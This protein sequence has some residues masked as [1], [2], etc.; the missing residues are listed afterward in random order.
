[1]NAITVAKDIA[2]GWKVQAQVAIDGRTSVDPILTS[3]QTSKIHVRSLNLAKAADKKLD[4]LIKMLNDALPAM[5]VCWASENW[6]AFT[7]QELSFSQVNTMLHNGTCQDNIVPNINPNYFKTAFRALC[8]RTTAEVPRLEEQALYGMQLTNQKT[9]K[10]SEGDQ[11]LSSRVSHAF[12]STTMQRSGPS[13]N[14]F[15][16]HI[17]NLGF[18]TRRSGTLMDLKTLDSH[19]VFEMRRPC[20][21]A[22]VATLCLGMTSTARS[23]QR[24]VPMCDLCYCVFIFTQIPDQYHPAIVEHATL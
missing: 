9:Y 10:L 19:T 8:V 23:S 14:L 15:R 3:L 18:R 6:N 2:A 12:G 20:S 16:L 1:M 13:C 17:L 7:A 22:K 4:D 21:S 11:A 24:A 5:S